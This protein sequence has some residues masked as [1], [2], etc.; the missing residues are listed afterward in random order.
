MV[1]LMGP[2]H[3]DGASGKFGG[4]MVFFTSK[5]RNVARQL[6][7]PVNKMSSTQ[8]DQRIYIGGTGRAVGEIKAFVGVTAVVA[9]FAQRLI[10]MGLIPS[11]QSKQSYLVKYILQHYLN[12]TTNY[13]AE[14]A[15][16][17]SHTSYTSFQAA[18]TTLGLV[19]FD[20]AYA[21]VAPYDKA[22]GVYLIAKTGIDLGF[23][24]T[25][26]TV[27]ITAWV[28]ATITAMVAEFTT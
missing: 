6:V 12:S 21:S 5:G 11:G 8:G 22:L 4:S 26:F 28:S 15:A 24:G 9:K 13:A 25:F 7:I 16:L 1:K 14:L 3:S 10:T 27:P 19:E 20:L 17:T 2:M 23:T 18:A